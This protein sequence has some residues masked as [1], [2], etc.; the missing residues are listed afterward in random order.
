MDWEPSCVKDSNIETV[1]CCR[2]IPLKL[3]EDS[4]LYGYKTVVT[5]DVDGWMF[6]DYWICSSW[7]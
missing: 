7:K 4:L 3:R 2:G 1:R 5:K 6:L